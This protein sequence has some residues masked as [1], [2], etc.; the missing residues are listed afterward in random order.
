MVITYLMLQAPV[1]HVPSQMFF[2]DGK[3]GSRTRNACQVVLFSQQK[4]LGEPLKLSHIEKGKV[5]GL[6]GFPK[7]AFMK[8]RGRIISELK[9]S[10]TSIVTE[11]AQVNISSKPFRFFSA[12]SKKW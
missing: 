1:N 7:K 12:V 8:Q 6:P 5:R 2:T 3:R 9:F 4:G 10:Y 11:K